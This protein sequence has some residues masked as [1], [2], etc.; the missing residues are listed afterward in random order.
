MRAALLQ[1]AVR[2][3]E[4]PK[5]RTDR[6]VSLVGDCRSADLVVLP[7][8]WTVGAFAFEDFES[9]AETVDGETVR[10]MGAAAADAGVWLHAGSIIER[11]PDGRLFNTALLFAPDGRL[12]RTYR[13]IHRFGFDRGEAALLARGERPATAVLA[14]VGGTGPTVG[15]ATCYDLR[16]PE[17]F[18]QLVDRGAEL[19]VVAA[20]W[21]AVRREHWLLLARARAVECQAYVLACSTTGA[22]AGVEQAGH[23]VVVGPRGEVLAEAGEAEQTLVVDLDPGAVAVERAAFPVL[24]DR[25]L[26]VPAPG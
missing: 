12:H 1:I 18:R 19:L 23:S 15:L 25:I 17:L 24:R 4:D 13:K 2:P 14:P 10:R 21:P 6:V 11:A 5:E 9:C 22:H 20:G 7:E 3:E 8:L 16:F 26:G